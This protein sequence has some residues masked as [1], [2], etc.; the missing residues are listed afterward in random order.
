MTNFD[1]KVGGLPITANFKDLKEVNLQLVQIRVWNKSG[2][3][4]GV[5]ICF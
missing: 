5:Y 1:T 3:I 4:S 2:N